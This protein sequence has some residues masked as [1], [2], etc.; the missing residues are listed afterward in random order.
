MFELIYRMAITSD[1]SL[2]NSTLYT[3]IIRILRE[4][5]IC[6]RLKLFIIDILERHTHMRLYISKYYTHRDLT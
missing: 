4:T 2:V 1:G 6:L 5:I 3:M